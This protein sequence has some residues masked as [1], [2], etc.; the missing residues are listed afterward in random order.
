MSRYNVSRA[1]ILMSRTGMEVEKREFS[2][3]LNWRHYLLKTY[4][5][6]KKNWQNHWKWLNKPFRNTSKSLEWFRSKE[7]GFRTSWSREIARPIKTYLKTLR[8]QVLFHLLYSPDVAPSDYHLFRSMAHRPAHQ[9]FRFNEEVKKWID[10]WMASK[11]ASFF[12]DGIR[13][14]QKDR[15][16]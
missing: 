6:H 16:K 11:D 14:F 15:R 8:W 7:I 10:S 9:H 2:K 4:A 3:I 1:V 5:K 13:Q 12:R